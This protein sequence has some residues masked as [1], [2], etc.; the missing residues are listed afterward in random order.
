M[1]QLVLVRGDKNFLLE[2][3]VLEADGEIVDL[4]GASIDFRMQRYG[5]STL[6]LDKAGEVT[7]GTLGLCQVKIEQELV[8]L[9]GEFFAELQ[10]TWIAEGKVLTVPGISIKVLKDLPK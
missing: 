6:T 1:A 9:S 5:E 3:S 7:N 2:F 10:I 4:T 8:D